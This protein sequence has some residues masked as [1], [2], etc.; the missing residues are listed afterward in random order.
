MTT[1]RELKNGLQDKFELAKNERDMR[2]YLLCL[3]ALESG[4]R[5]SDLLKLDWYAIDYDKAELSYLN[6]KGKKRQTQKLSRTMLGYLLRYQETLK[7]SNVYNDK[8]FYNNYKNSVL[9]RVTA[10]RRTQKEF[11]INFHQLRKEAGR[12]IANQKGVV[13]ASKY[14]GHSR[15]ST[16]DIYLGVSDSEYINQMK[17]VSI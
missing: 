1:Y 16:T 8:I 10:N 5:V 12:N 7:V 4:A 6:T 3:L 9:S 14:L 2:F 13:M 17:D 15:T 11:G